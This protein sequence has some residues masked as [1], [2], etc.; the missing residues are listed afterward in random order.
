MIDIESATK[1]AQL[2]TKEKIYKKCTQNQIS[3]Y[4]TKIRNFER[5][6]LSKL[7]NIAAGL[8]NMVYKKCVTALIL[9][10][11]QLC[12]P[13]DDQTKQKQ[14]ALRFQIT[15]TYLVNCQLIASKFF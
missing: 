7:N 13:L 5:V 10:K 8:H 1:K 9:L 3:P 4:F 12:R 11:L 6:G 2:H 15:P 14:K